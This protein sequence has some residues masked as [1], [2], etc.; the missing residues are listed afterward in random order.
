MG[1]YAAYLSGAFFADVV[2]KDD[3]TTVKYSFAGGPTLPDVK[4]RQVSFRRVGNRW[5]VEDGKRP[6]QPAKK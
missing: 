3:I 6:E 4:D 1:G 2:L 5:F